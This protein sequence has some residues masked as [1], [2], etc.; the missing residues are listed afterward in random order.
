MNSSR[1]YLIRALH[2]WIEDNS[3]TPYVLVDCAS[4]D[5]Q[6]PREFINDGRIVLNISAQA[7]QDLELGNE[8][9]HFHARF[10]GRAMVVSFPVAA[11]LAVYARENGRGMVFEGDED[12]T[13]PPDN[14][15]NDEGK[16]RLR[17]VR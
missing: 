7:V 5:V 14:G 12:T 15:G 11:V 17:V 10:S 3:A 4:N 1:P 9:I 16:P 2:Q 6:V 13:P 8:T